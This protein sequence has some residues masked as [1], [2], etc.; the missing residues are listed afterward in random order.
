MSSTTAS[1][2]ATLCPAHLVPGPGDARP[3]DGGLERRRGRRALRRLRPLRAP[4]PDV[5]GA[6]CAGPT[7]PR[8]RGAAALGES[9]SPRAARY[10]RRLGSGPA[11]SYA[12]ASPFS[13]PR[14]RGRFTPSRCGGRSRGTTS[15]RRSGGPSTR[16]RAGTSSTAK[17][18]RHLT[19]LPDDLLA[20]VDIATM[21]HALDPSPF[22]DHPLVELA[23]RLPSRLKRRG[24][25]GKLVLRRAVADLLP[26]EILGATEARLRHPR[27][28]LAAWRAAEMA[29]DALFSV[30]ARRRPFFEAWAVRALFDAHLSGRADH[31]GRLADAHA[32][33]VVRPVPGLTADGRPPRS[34]RAPS[35]GVRDR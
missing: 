27:L 35:A 23:L 31:G 22:L 12:R 13:T 20:K 34:E 11:E 33:A 28:R 7:R 10:L 15:T 17:A 5:G 2:S 3:R 25:E 19:H 9:L 8:A 24:G 26:A 18:R 21:A 16:P 30:S 14:R 4:V 1:P 32:R 6:G 29:E